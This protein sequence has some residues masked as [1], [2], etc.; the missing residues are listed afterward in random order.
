MTPCYLLPSVEGPKTGFM[1]PHPPPHLLLLWVPTQLGFSFCN[2]SRSLFLKSFYSTVSRFPGSVALPHPAPAPPPRISPFPS[3]ALS[4]ERLARSPRTPPRF[5]L[6]LLSFSSSSHS[7][8]SNSIPPGS[9]LSPHL[10]SSS[11]ISFSSTFRSSTKRRDDWQEGVISRFFWKSC[12]KD[13]G[14]FSEPV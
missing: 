7:F 1:G 5:F 3:P 9:F 12:P 8:L 14:T 2:M 11:R 10:L 4:S 13:K 6:Q